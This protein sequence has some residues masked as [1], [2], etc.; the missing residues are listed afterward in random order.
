ML[1]L[2]G[3]ESKEAALGCSVCWVAAGNGLGGCSVRIG[4]VLR[5]SVFFIKPPVLSGGCSVCWVAA[6]SAWGAA[7]NGLGGCW[8]RVGRLL[9]ENWVGVATERFLFY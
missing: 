8:E 5:R 7:G 1:G 3:T 4:R 9:C 6:G 2:L